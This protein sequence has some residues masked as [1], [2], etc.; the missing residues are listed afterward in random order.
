MLSNTYFL[1]LRPGAEVLKRFE[2]IHNF[3]GINTNFLTDS[4]GF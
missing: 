2:G 4:G 1:Y 3:T